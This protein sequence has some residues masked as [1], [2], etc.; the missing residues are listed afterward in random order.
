MTSESPDA[1]VVRPAGH[2]APLP[3]LAQRGD[4]GDRPGAPRDLGGFA[5]SEQL[6]APRGTR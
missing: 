6:P 3:R 2:S 1:A 5:G 4:L